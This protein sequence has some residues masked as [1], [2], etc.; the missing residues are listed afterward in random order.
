MMKLPILFLVAFFSSPSKSSICSIN[1]S[2][3]FCAG[4]EETD[5]YSNMIITIAPQDIVDL[6][7]TNSSITTLNATMF[8]NYQYVHTLSITHTKLKYIK[9]G[10]FYSLDYLEVLNL[11]YN[12]IESFN[13]RA[14]SSIG[15][16]TLLDLSYNNLESISNFNLKSFNS[17]VLNISNNKMTHLEPEII[18]KLNVSNYFY[19]IIN[20]NPWNCSEIRWHKYLSPALL[21]AF[22]LYPQDSEKNDEQ[23]DDKNFAFQ[24]V[25]EYTSSVFPTQEENNF[26]VQFLEENKKNITLEKYST[27]QNNTINCNYL[28]NCSSYCIFWCLGGVW[29]GIILGNIC[30]IKRLIC[31][32]VNTQ[33][34]ET[35]QRS[36]I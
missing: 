14:L 21:L 19:L 33:D 24:A 29:I 8:Q 17:L 9:K 31:S 12:C 32:S 30:K 28:K 26:V 4:M 34:Q 25:E 22:C 16:L 11:S 7:I 15:N 13:F 6:S 18:Q 3:I 27:P 5:F 10:T 36:K 20:N 2:K 23:K 35:Q 1:N